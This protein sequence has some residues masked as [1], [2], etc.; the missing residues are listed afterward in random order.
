VSKPD[1]APARSLVLATVLV[2]VTGARVVRAVALDQE[3]VGI[4]PDLLGPQHV[5]HIRDAQHGV[6]DIDQQ[7]GVPVLIDV[8][9]LISTGQ[10]DICPSSSSGTAR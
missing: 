10:S 7:L 2:V 1:A 8:G 3:P 6:V 9:P 4:Q 5:L